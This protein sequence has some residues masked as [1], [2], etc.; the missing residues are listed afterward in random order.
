MQ[1]KPIIWVRMEVFTEVS[2]AP[3]I[4]GIQGDTDRIKEIK[5][6]CSSATF[7]ERS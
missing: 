2:F 3:Q 6:R 1:K 5:S 4:F 7:Q